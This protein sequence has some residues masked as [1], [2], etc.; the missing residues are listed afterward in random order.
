MT[1]PPIEE[2]ATF[3]W[4]DSFRGD[5]R[6][7]AFLAELSRVNDNMSV[8]IVALARCAT[9][10]DAHPEVEDA[11]RALIGARDRVTAIRHA[12]ET[13]EPPEPRPIDEAL[14]AEAKA[15]VTQSGLASTK[16]L[17]RKFD[18]GPEDAEHV[19]DVLHARGVVGPR[20]EGGKGRQVLIGPDS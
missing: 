2:G 10:D 15:L 5:D 3:S 18:V 20:V 4:L 9:A 16:I 17:Q 19:L 13:D 6:I 8:A 14:V 11:L 1:A 12:M 7:D